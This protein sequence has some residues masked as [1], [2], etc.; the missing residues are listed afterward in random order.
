MW[1]FDSGSDGFGRSGGSS[2]SGSS[3]V[4]GSYCDSGCGNNISGGCAIGGSEIA[5]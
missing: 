5:P 4:S 3:G 2:G 1:G